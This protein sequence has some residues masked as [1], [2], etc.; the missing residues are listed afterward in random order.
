MKEK[1]SLE[2]NKKSSTAAYKRNPEATIERAK[3]RYRKDPGLERE[4]AK[5]GGEQTAR[6]S[7]CAC[8]GL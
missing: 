5:E 4:K 6:E 7:E 8:A 1:S 2:A 3:K